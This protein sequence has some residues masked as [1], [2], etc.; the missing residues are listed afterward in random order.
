MVETRSVDKKAGQSC[1]EEKA[2]R[3]VVVRYSLV[4]DWILSC[5]ADQQVSPLYNNDADK[6]GSVACVLQLFPSI[7]GLKI[8]QWE[9]PHMF[10]W[11]CVQVEV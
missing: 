7:V 9:Q 8:E 10:F 3:H 5:L 1:L 4:E 2:K 11:N 6:E